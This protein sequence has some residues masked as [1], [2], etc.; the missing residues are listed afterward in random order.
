MSPEEPP[1]PMGDYWDKDDRLGS[2][3]E[4]MSMLTDRGCRLR[5]EPEPC[6]VCGPWAPEKRTWLR[7]SLR[8]SPFVGLFVK[9]AWLRG[10][11][12]YPVATRAHVNP[13]I[14]SPPPPLSI[15]HIGFEA[16]GWLG[17]G[18]GR[19]TTHPTNQRFSMGLYWSEGHG[20]SP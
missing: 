3:R 16:Q 17:L 7:E 19:T 6:L 12:T 18:L 1:P 8:L 4:A 11:P 2:A 15:G 9:S 10:S 13:T 14:T 20:L 5:E